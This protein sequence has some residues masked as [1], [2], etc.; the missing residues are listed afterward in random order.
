MACVARHARR[1]LSAGVCLLMLAGWECLAIAEAQAQAPTTVQAGL[2]VELLLAMALQDVASPA[3]PFNATLQLTQAG[4]ARSMTLFVDG[5]KIRVQHGNTAQVERQDL[6]RLWLFD[7]K[8]H[9][10]LDLPL[11]R[12]SLPPPALLRQEC[13]IT[14]QGE[15][16]VDGRRAARYH[17]RM[18]GRFIEPQLVRPTE[19]TQQVELTIWHSP[20]LGALLKREGPGNATMVMTG[21]VT[22]PQAA[23]LFQIPEGYR[24]APLPAAFAK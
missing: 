12:D 14:P 21:I 18:P 6:G 17:I 1:V 3:Q 23:E 16:D 24:R 4:A 20:E 7:L 8:Q 2:P 13:V 22:G 15:E 9:T 11:A 5:P 19:E 10:F